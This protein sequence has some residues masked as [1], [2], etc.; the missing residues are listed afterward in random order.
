MMKGNDQM[1]LKIR[2]AR[3]KSE[4]SCAVVPCVEVVAA[5][6]IFPLL[7]LLLKHRL[8]AYES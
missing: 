4:D 6:T 1:L 7:T 8:Q 5:S 2:P 3:L